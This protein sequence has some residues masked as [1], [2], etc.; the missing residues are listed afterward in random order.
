[1]FKK[2]LLAYDGSEPARKAFDRCIEMTRS[3]HGE[4]SIVGVIRPPEFAEDVETEALIDSARSR[5]DREIAELSP[6][7]IAAG[8]S[9]RITV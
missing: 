5:F 2:I 7:A 4:L 8:I 9:P 1:M 6:R 3:F